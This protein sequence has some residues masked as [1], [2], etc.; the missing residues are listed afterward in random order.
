MINVRGQKEF[1]DRYFLVVNLVSLFVWPPLINKINDRLLRR[2]ALGE[3]KGRSL[4][5]AYCLATERP[6]QT[7]TKGGRVDRW[8]GER[9]F[10]VYHRVP[11]CRFS[12]ILT[13]MSWIMSLTFYQNMSPN[14]AGGKKTTNRSSC[15]ST[16]GPAVSWSR[17]TLKRAQ[18]KM[19]QVKSICFSSWSITDGHIH[20]TVYTGDLPFNPVA[21]KCSTWLT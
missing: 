10:F 15:S 6:T 3:G 13:A 7:K 2:H 5:F 17:S 20:E 14:V 8:S 18:M 12:P 4:I 19:R 21:S 16:T 11:S 1:S 9:I